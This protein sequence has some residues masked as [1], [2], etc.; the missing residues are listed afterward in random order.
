M[1]IVMLSISNPQKATQAE[2]YYTEENY[3]QKNSE[4]GH[5]KGSALKEVGIKEGQTVTQELYLSLLHGF[6]P[7]D[8][9][10]LTKGAG[11]LD[12]RAGIDL[13][14]SAPKSVSTL[15]EIAEANGFETL[16]LQI[17]E[18]H[19]KAVN[20]SMNKVEEEYLYTRISVDGKIK[21]VKAEGMLYASFQHD[22]SRAL[23]PQLHTHNFIFTPVLKEGKFNAHTNEAF[24]NN[25]LYLGQFYR[26]ELAFNLNKLGF[27][28]EITSIEKGLFELKE[29]P[30]DIINEFSKRSQE[31]EKLEEK[32][33]KKYPK[34]T[35]T[36]IR[37]RITQESKKAKTKVDRDEVRKTN[38]KRADTLGYSKKWLTRLTT[39]I[40]SRPTPIQNRSKQALNYLNKSLH[41]ITNQESTFSK[42]DILKYAMKFSLKYSLRE[43]ELIQQF[44]NSPILKLGKNIYS[45]KEMV[46]IEKEIIKE[47]R[48]GQNSLTH[49]IHELIN[50]QNSTVQEL[51]LD[52]K[53][54]L[55]M[56]LN[57][58][59]KYNAV[60]GDAGTGKTFALGKLKEIT[61]EHIDI[62]GLSYT[63]KAAA[64]L[65]EVGIESHTLHTYLQQD[66]AQESH[67]AKLYIVDET[68]LAGSKQLYQLM[69]QSKNEN[70]RIIFIG[71]TKQFSSIQAGNVFSDMQKFGIKTVH[72][73]QTQRQK[74]A[75]T[76]S[77]VKAYNNND[78]DLA[79]ELLKKNDLFKEIEQY[80][81]RIDYAVES[82]LHKNQ[83]LI[84]TSTN[85]ERKEINQQV[86][87]KIDNTHTNH[88]FI[89][90]ESKQIK[91][92]DSYFSES[93]ALGDII[94]INGSI[95]KFKRGEQGEIISIKKNSITIETN[96][97]QIKEIDLTQYGADINAHTKTTKPFKIGEKI[98]FT[99]NIKNSPIKNGVMGVIDN[100]KKD[101]SIT[102]S[103]QNGK[104]YDFN[105]NEYNYID[106]AY[107]ITDI[108]SQGVSA[109]S[110]LILADSRMSSKN[111]FYV[112]VTR[113]KQN[114]EVITD[115]QKL[116]QERIKNASNKDS[117]LNYTGDKHDKQRSNTQKTRRDRGE[118]NETEQSNPRTRQ[119]DLYDFRNIRSYFQ[120]LKRKFR[121]S[122]L[123]EIR[124]TF[125]MSKMQK[126]EVIKDTTLNKLHTKDKDI[127]MD[128]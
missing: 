68:S 120:T 65:E 75:V 36:E 42:E 72:L 116:L 23:D 56:I 12:R 102:T 114:I 53:N 43:S 97:K 17:R 48:H 74:S 8:N 126:K 40:N 78:T 104:S 29:I 123:N 57:T 26:N 81:E 124:R 38:K 73:K 60:Q 10:P 61:G 86:R 27:T 111:S 28:I 64:G 41:A 15:L 96:S 46:N 49:S 99:K 103:L 4:I 52:Q 6:N 109:D 51:T 11:S 7:K 70:S 59:D 115:N 1:E 88:N 13:T 118:S 121:G 66:K 95:P 79:L 92:S 39:Q 20:L 82:Y 34:E 110:V 108:K 125:N 127:S 45:T 101:G 19:E 5:F 69:Q 25:K 71:D 67:R 55:E 128:R 122:S 44:K 106:Y 37:A 98:I 91:A 113:A 35:L 21:S 54:M 117:T 90:K 18:A 31:I 58:K 14:F 63:G 100:I 33:K 47:I 32:Y 119:R 3:Y 2:S 9:T 76:K 89:I 93:Y 107:A 24:F 87:D 94:S 85:K 77:I 50:N 62:I 112:Q 83:P 30:K 16:A 80:E 105:I 22:T 84:L